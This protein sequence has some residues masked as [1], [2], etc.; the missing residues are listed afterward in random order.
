MNRNVQVFVF[1]SAPW[2]VARSF[3]MSMKRF[4]VFLL[5]VALGGCGGCGKSS[6]PAVE[7][8]ESPA[9]VP[10]E[11]LKTLNTHQLQSPAAKSNDPQSIP[12]PVTTR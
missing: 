7:P 4:A 12:K 11:P 10:R 9:P 8:P 1:E 2:S 3:K 5:S 6:R